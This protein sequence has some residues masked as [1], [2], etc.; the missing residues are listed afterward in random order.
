MLSTAL[1]TTL[2][3]AWVALTPLN[4]PMALMGGI[5]LSLWQRM[6]ATRDIDILLAL[7]EADVAAVVGMLRP[8]HFV[9]V[10]SAPVKRLGELSILQLTYEPPDAEVPISVDLLFGQSEYLKGVLARAVRV[11]LPGLATELAV[12]SCE[13]LVLLKLQ[14]GRIIDRADAVALLR[15]NRAGI[16][17]GYLQQSA[18]QLGVARELDDA[19]NDAAQA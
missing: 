16:D 12:V 1:L 17:A 9:P 18:A 10:N 15:E 3:K 19:W 11:S 2:E 14:A 7:G 5:A 13:D 4:R 6:R 8:L